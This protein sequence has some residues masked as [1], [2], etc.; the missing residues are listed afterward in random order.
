MITQ[1]IAAGTVQV[2]FPLRQLAAL[3]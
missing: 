3:A 2:G 1:M